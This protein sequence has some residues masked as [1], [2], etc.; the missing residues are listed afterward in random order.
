MDTAQ[1][2]VK[3]EFRNNTQGYIGAVVITRKGDERQ[4]MVE[5]FGRIFLTDEE[6]ALTE[7]SRAR[8]ENSP[9]REVEI[10]HRD[11]KSGDEIVRFRAP[12]LERVTA[13]SPQRPTGN[14]LD[15]E[16]VGT[17]QARTPVA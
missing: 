9:F 1:R 2:P 15:G 10:I 6:V 14:F 7:R 12:K 13:D 3:H 8:A 17:P 5:P 4:Q 16:E 11:L